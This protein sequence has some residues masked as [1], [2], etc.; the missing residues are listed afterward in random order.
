MF[1][2]HAVPG[3]FCQRRGPVLVHFLAATRK[4]AGKQ[5][6]QAKERAGVRWS[7]RCGAS[8]HVQAF[9]R[10]GGRSK[11]VVLL[12]C[13]VQVRE[14]CVVGFLVIACLKYHSQD[15]SDDVLQVQFR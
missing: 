3:A 1:C 12:G 8:L 6:R 7:S 9:G 2:A 10:A 15:R 5:Y 13:W 14:C 11:G 4:E